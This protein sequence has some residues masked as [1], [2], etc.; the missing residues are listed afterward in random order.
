MGGRTAGGP[1][2]GV[3]GGPA[4]GG[5]LSWGDGGFFLPSGRSFPDTYGAIAILSDQLPDMT[6]AQMSFAA[7]HET[8]TTIR[9][10]PNTPQ[11]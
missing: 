11:N 1:V 3:R 7:S 9:T 2:R 10:P 5:G 4:D 8:L 6:D